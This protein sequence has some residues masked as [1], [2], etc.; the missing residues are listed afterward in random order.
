MEQRQKSL[1]ATFSTGRTH[2]HCP[3]WQPRV[4]KVLAQVTKKWLVFTEKKNFHASQAASP[5][6]TCFSCAAQWWGYQMS[7]KNLSKTFTILPYF[8]LPHSWLSPL[9]M[10]WEG[11]KKEKKDPELVNK[12]WCWFDQNWTCC[13]TNIVLSVL[14]LKHLTAYW[15]DPKVISSWLREEFDRWDINLSNW[16]LQ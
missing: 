3:A 4:N 1:R 12:P 6:P 11:K 16:L 14:L 10:M 5:A 15:P 9:P 7:R 8:T 13:S 2:T